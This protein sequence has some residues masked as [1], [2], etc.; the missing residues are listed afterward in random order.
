MP[1]SEGRRS[2]PGQSL[3]LIICLWPKIYP[4][5]LGVR[6]LMRPNIVSFPYLFP[7]NLYLGTWRA[8]SVYPN[9]SPPTSD[10]PEVVEYGLLGMPMTMEI[11]PR[12]FRCINIPSA[13]YRF[14]MGIYVSYF[15]PRFLS[16]SRSSRQSG[17]VL[18]S[19]TS[20]S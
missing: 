18:C 14:E 8:Q 12:K 16:I 9:G 2:F 3:L 17:G 4:I 7:L 6:Y 1:F 15:A 5:I 20:A 11:P 19:Q 10:G 13:L